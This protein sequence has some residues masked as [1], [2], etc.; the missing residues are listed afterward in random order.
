MLGDCPVSPG[1]ECR[2]GRR[3]A[4]LCPVPGQHAQQGCCC[5][6]SL[7]HA[8]VGPAG[9]QRQ[10]CWQLFL[11]LCRAW[12]VCQPPASRALGA[13]VWCLLTAPGSVE[14][15]PAQGT[16]A[17]AVSPAGACPWGDP[18]RAACCSC[19]LP[20]GLLSFLSPWIS[21]CR[22]LTATLM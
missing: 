3:G 1:A 20:S 14:V 19:L 4:L 21:P 12:A 15:L 22:G 11:L 5:T 8:E 10:I 6:K 9:G 18:Q 7:S 2:A 17:A 13:Q 16:A